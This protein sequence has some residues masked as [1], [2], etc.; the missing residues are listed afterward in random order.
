MIKQVV[1]L[2]CM[3]S[4]L[5][6]AFTHKMARITFSWF[7]TA[8]DLPESQGQFG[9]FKEQA[10]ISTA[11]PSCQLETLQTCQFSI[12]NWSFSL[13]QEN[14]LISHKFLVPAVKA[15]LDLQSYTWFFFHLFL[16]LRLYLNGD[17]LTGSLPFCWK[18]YP[19]SRSR[20]HFFR[21]NFL[22]CSHFLL[23][24]HVFFP[25]PRGGWLFCAAFHAYSDG[26]VTNGPFYYVSAMVMLFI[27]PLYAAISS[28][29]S[30][31]STVAK[32]V[33]GE[34]WVNSVM[35]CT[36]SVVSLS[37]QCQ[38]VRACVSLVCISV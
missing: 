2:L 33:S 36:E 7:S 31:C 14:T 1:S 38:W 34:E 23:T 25:Y 19:S 11:C 37:Q 3:D 17:L 10:A 20:S 16:L 13:V 30:F 28:L 21:L 6:Q 29:V 27:G 32:S 12:F 9:G 5:W 4:F 15:K 26:R 18:K 22:P 35:S 24:S 8:A